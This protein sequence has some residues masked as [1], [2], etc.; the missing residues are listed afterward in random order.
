MQIWETVNIPMGIYMLNF[1]TSYFK[2]GWL[3]IEVPYSVGILRTQRIIWHIQF[4]LRREQALGEV[5][6]VNKINFVTSVFLPN[7]YVTSSSKRDLKS[8]KAVLC[9]SASKLTM[10]KMELDFNFCFS[11]KMTSWKSFLSITTN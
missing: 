6:T 3:V 1:K 9:Y 10:W 11:S 2:K 5:C 7:T 8:A 4:C